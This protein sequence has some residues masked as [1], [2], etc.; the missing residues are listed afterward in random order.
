MASTHN[1]QTS[2]NEFA[3]CQAQ[4]A[5]HLSHTHNA[6]VSTYSEFAAE[7]HAS[8]STETSV[9]DIQVYS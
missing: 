4:P 7:L 3:K 5:D 8:T 1:M 6:I 9:V 2:N